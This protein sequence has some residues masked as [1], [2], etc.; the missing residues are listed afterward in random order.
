MHL[1]YHTPLIRKDIQDED[2]VKKT[3]KGMICAKVDIDRSNQEWKE[4]FS[5]K[6]KLLL[7][8]T[9]FFFGFYTIWM[10][11]FST[12]HCKK[13]AILK[14]RRHLYTLKS[15]TIITSSIAIGISFDQVLNLFIELNYQHLGPDGAFLVW[16]SWKLMESILFFVIK[17]IW[18]IYVV[19]KNPEVCILAGRYFP[20]Q[21]GPRPMTPGGS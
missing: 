1:S 6:P 21:Q 2:F 5:I 12:R 11:R 10:Y 19:I 20:G 4:V 18:L 16:W 15:Q 8:L 14:Y 17:N 3:L 13:F 7:C 9:C